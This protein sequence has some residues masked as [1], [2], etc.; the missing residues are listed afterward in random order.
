M[1]ELLADTAVIVTGGARGL[2]REY[3]LAAA[4]A[5]AAVVVGDILGDGAEE[6][7][8]MIRA[9]G[10][11]AVAVVGDVSDASTAEALVETCMAS[12]GRLDGLVNNAGEIFPGSSL[13]LPASNAR[14]LIEVNVVGSIFCGAAVARAMRAT[15][16]RGSIVNVSS[17]ALQ[18]MDDLALYGTT[19][20]AIA[21]LTWGW[22]LEWQQYGIRCN[23][24]APL[25]HTAMSDQMD[26]PDEYKGPHPRV[27]APVVVHLLSERSSS[28]NGQILRFDG[29][30]FGL[31]MPAH[32]SV[33][34]E[35]GSW[36]V[37]E[38]NDA[39]AGPL[40]GGVAPVGLMN[41]PRPRWVDVD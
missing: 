4:Q 14:R 7:A 27:V 26:I 30:R 24:I 38:I 31:V 41:S 29:E 33:V 6:T 11:R 5:G 23:A 3:A 32:L 40:S 22:A 19:K 1:T 10:G 39:L 25:A 15:G 21:S 35:R 34:T 16:T 2:G 37:D 9:F 18:G 20:G 8:E 28:L 36:S 13:D 12:F 17:G